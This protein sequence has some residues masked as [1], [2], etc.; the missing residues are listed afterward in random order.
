MPDFYK[1]VG[2]LAEGLQGVAHWNHDV[3]EDAQN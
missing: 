1:N 3:S 2:K